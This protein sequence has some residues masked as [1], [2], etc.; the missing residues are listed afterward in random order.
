MSHFFKEQC[1]Y[2]NTKNI[3]VNEVSVNVY[4]N[5]P[6]EWMFP[7]PGSPHRESMWL[8]HSLPSRLWAILPAR[9]VAL[10]QC[11]QEVT[12]LLIFGID[13]NGGAAVDVKV[14]FYLVVGLSNRYKGR[15]KFWFGQ[16]FDLPGS[17]T[18]LMCYCILD[19]YFLC[20][21]MGGLHCLRSLGMP[22]FFVEVFTNKGKC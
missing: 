6:T 16:K 19:S 12:K 7:T 13:K 15:F 3:K 1:A 4:L 5:H 14:V 8:W 10:L 9:Q 17:S 2:V 11:H 20:K 18:C 21:N 22:Y